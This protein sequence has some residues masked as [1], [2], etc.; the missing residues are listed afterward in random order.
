MSESDQNP[1]ISENEKFKEKKSYAS[2]A[3][4]KGL[5]LDLQPPSLSSNSMSVSP[6]ASS[7]VDSPST[8]LDKNTLSHLNK[9]LKVKQKII[10]SKEA[11]PKSIGEIMNRSPKA[12]TFSSANNT[13]PPPTPDILETIPNLQLADPPPANLSIKRPSKK[14]NKQNSTRTDIFAAK[15]ASAVDDVD[16]SDSDETFVYETNINEDYSGNGANEDFDNNTVDPQ[17]HETTETNEINDLAS[18]SDNEAP[19]TTILES[20]PEPVNPNTQSPSSTTDGESTIGA[21]TRLLTALDL[22]LAQAPALTPALALAL[23]QALAQTP[24]TPLTQPGLGPL[25]LQAPGNGSKA[26][27]ITR[28]GTQRTFSSSSVNYSD[29]KRAS[30]PFHNNYYASSINGLNSFPKNNF[31]FD[32]FSGYQDVTDD[33]GSDSAF[34]TDNDE[35]T[36]LR[37]YRHKNRHQR[38][39]SQLEDNNMETEE[40][41]VDVD[42][43]SS[44]ESS[45]SSKNIMVSSSSTTVPPKPGGKTNDPKKTPVDPTNSITS[46]S[47]GK[48]KSTTLS[49]KLRST[50]SKLFDK[51]GAQ[52]RRYSIIPDDIDIEDF[53]DEL[54]YYDN[55]RFPH[56]GTNNNSLNLNDHSPLINQQ[57]SRIPHYRSL[58]L[59]PQSL[60]RM[61]KAKRYLSAGQ[62]LMTNPGS[63]SPSRPPQANNQNN[64]DIFPFPYPEQANNQGYYLGFD[65]FDEETGSIDEQPFDK[66][67]RKASAMLGNHYLSN[68]NHHFL[69]PRK[70][71]F[72]HSNYNAIKRTIY[73]MISIISILTIGFLSGFFIASTKDLTN[74]AITDIQNAVVS[75]DELLFNMVVEAMNPGWFTIGVKDVE[76]DI[77]ARSGYLSAAEDDEGVMESVVETV[78]LGT[79]C[80]LETEM[81]FDGILFNRELVEQI[82]EIKLVQPGKNLTGVVAN[83]DTVPPPDNS[84]KWEVISK[85]PFDLVVK[86]VLK[87]SLPLSKGTKSIAVSKTSYI[88]PNYDG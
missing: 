63:P 27:A 2:V 56:H 86:G 70:N 83:N 47:T 40:D 59:N 30:S 19:D 20:N 88:D 48:K 60:K 10:T 82:G 5:K 13:G 80:N 39:R 8:K 66:S 37:S 74:V 78:L 18:D 62:P 77:F 34:D 43:V 26:S 33:M 28:P 68:N 23:A 54:I 76:L 46:K 11:Q 45:K 73:T 7:S 16:S 79:V 57:N 58:N 32:K 14:L 55:V 6:I 36:G 17:P 42:D 61:N 1:P 81:T 35:R 41:E 75:Q 24:Q 53:D 12:S 51:K 69:L 67:S 50:T 72:V 25:A 9:S 49:S 71:S 3:N 21:S 52:P 38:K 22:A 87:Y 85:S 84:A 44:H 4:S 15:L 65:D 64:S 29:D 31:D